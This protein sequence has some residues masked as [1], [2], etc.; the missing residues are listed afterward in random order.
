MPTTP[1]TPGWK[2]EAWG[3]PAG[4]ITRTAAT[5]SRAAHR[6]AQGA[7]NPHEGDDQPEEGEAHS[8][9]PGP[10]A[11]SQGGHETADRVLGAPAL[12]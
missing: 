8:R 7:A 11:R 4:R 1:F 6:Q 5:G 10:A 3:K 2:P 9:R 12:P